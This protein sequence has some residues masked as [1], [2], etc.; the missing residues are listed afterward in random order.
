VLDL[1]EENRAQIE[2]FVARTADAQL[3]PLPEEYG[4]DMQLLPDD[5]HD[6]F[7]YALLERR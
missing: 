4:Q 6:G 1:P 3:T 2:D 7:Y 5:S